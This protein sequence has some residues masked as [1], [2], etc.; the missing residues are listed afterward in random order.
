MYDTPQ[1]FG[2]ISRV[3]HWLMAI[4]FFFMMYTVIAWTI[5]EDNLGLMDYH[6]SVG[7]CL[8][9]LGAIRLIWALIQRKNRPHDSIYAHLGHR[10]LYVLMIA[11][12]AIGVLR[13]YGSARRDLEVFGVTVMQTAN[14]KIEWMTQLGH[15]LHGKLGLLLFALIIGHTLM[16]IYHQIRG[17]KIL[18]R[19]A[20]PRR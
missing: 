19:M 8:L 1:S 10:I 12:P 14:E 9:I 5:N 7:F 11:I 6:K 15:A 20:G 16:A 17:E 18:N 13:Q 3:L 2:T 4:G